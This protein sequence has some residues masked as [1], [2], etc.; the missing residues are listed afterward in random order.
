MH[1]FAP[2]DSNNSTLNNW[3]LDNS[4]WLL[5]FNEVIHFI[6]RWVQTMVSIL[7]SLDFINQNE[8]DRRKKNFNAKRFIWDI[9]IYA[10]QFIIS[11]K[12]EKSPL[13]RY[14]NA[15][16]SVESLKSHSFSLF[17]PMCRSQQT[18]CDFD[19]K[20]ISRQLNY[21]F[22]IHTTFS[23]CSTHTLSLARASQELYLVQ[24]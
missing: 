3:T 16:G 8:D 4:I 6:I 24:F 15:N 7:L 2:C 12:K 9:F 22:S 21:R 5:R 20:S 1:S 14:P 18:K 19:L 23:L 11:R 10:F 17:S 13:H